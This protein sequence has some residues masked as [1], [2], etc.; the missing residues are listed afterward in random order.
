M[1]LIFNQIET[2]K[3]IYAQDTYMTFAKSIL[4]LPIFQSVKNSERKRTTLK[5]ENIYGFKNV[6]MRFYPL[7]VGFDFD[8]FYYIL[9]KKM[10]SEKLS[11]T[12]NLTHFMKFHKVHPSN[13]K[14]YIEKLKQSLD[15]MLDFYLKFSYGPKTYK[16][17]LLTH[18]EENE[19]NREEIKITF[20]KFFEN[21]Y[22]HDPDLIF[23][24]QLDQFK[25]IKGDYAKIL[26][27]FCLLYTSDAADDLIGVDLG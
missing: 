3:K 12:I 4:H 2:K 19:E 15:N 21:F 10:K 25:E 26:Y 27:M 8:V 1:Q 20:S 11:F 14:V 6:E 18:V 17:H 9:Q 5:I 24:L 23:N 22:K 13:K 7:S 16:C